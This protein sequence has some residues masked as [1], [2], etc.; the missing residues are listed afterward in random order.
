MK[1]TTAKLKQIIKEELN[2]VLKEDKHLEKRFDSK[3]E[4]Q[5]YLND[6]AENEGAEGDYAVSEKADENGK[7]KLVDA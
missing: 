1:L 2:K 7:W 6:I 5:K 4:A 3:K